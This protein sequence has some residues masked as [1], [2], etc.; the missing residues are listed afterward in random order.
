MRI[1]TNEEIWTP[2]IGYSP[3][4]KEKVLHVNIRKRRK[5]S[6][7]V[8]VFLEVT[9]QEWE[10]FKE[11]FIS[12]LN[13]SEENMIKVYL[14]TVFFDKE[15]QGKI[16]V[17]G[18][19]VEKDANLKYGYD[20]KEATLDR[21][22]RVLNTFDKRW[23]IQN[24]Y[25]EAVHLSP[26]KVGKIVFDLLAND[27]EDVRGMTN[28]SSSSL[29]DAIA[30]HFKAEYGVDA[31]PVQS[32]GDSAEMGHFGKKGIVVPQSMRG[33]LEKSSVATPAEVKAS[34]AN[35]IKKSYS[36]DELE[37]NERGTLLKIEDVFD[38]VW[39]GIPREIPALEKFSTDYGFSQ[40]TL[41][42]LPKSVMHKLEIVDF[43]DKGIQG[44]CKMDECLIYVSKD[45]LKNYYL[46]LRVVVHELAHM[47]DGTSDGHKGHVS[48]MEELWCLV[49]A[50]EHWS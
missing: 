35:S 6:G 39:E 40:K 12:L 50:F 13:I 36:Y 48:T 14:G 45:V 32:I 31:I 25:S 3:E 1:E 23:E 30:G 46:A 47:V 19:F 28:Y 10:A 37:E 20:L 5:P 16:F 43:F 29:K 42:Y 27:W 34:F 17:K 22:R 8:E 41:L 11:R 9:Q 4:Y 26:Q 24:I 33:L 18:I 15:F 21:D 2:Y 44:L 49:Y 38:K 7:C